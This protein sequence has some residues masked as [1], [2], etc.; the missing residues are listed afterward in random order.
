MVI[1]GCPCTN[2]RASAARVPLP[3]RLP[4][5]P[6]LGRPGLPAAFGAATVAVAVAAFLALPEPRGRPGPRR[7][8]AATAAVTVLE[9]VD[10]PT[11]ARAAAAASRRPYS[12][13]RGLSSFSRLVISWRF[14]S[15]KSVT[16]LILFTSVDAVFNSHH[17]SLHLTLVLFANRIQ[18]CTKTFKRACCLSLWHAADQCAADERADGP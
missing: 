5:R 17:G 9:D 10:P 2:D 16:I 6:F 3:L 14:S 8:G 15:R 11:P 18:V 4:A 12:S 13:T 1:P 7:R